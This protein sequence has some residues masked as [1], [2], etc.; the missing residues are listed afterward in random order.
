MK[1]R[2]KERKKEK[3][4]KERKKE[5]GKEPPSNSPSAFQGRP[6]YTTAR[7]VRRHFHSHP[8]TAY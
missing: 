3:R 6:L 7:A 5:N 2:M 8:I 4:K 1:E